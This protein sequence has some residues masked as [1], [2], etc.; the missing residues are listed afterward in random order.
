VGEEKKTS[1]SRPWKR[2]GRLSVFLPFVLLAVLLAVGMYLD[3]GTRRQET[4]GRGLWSPAFLQRWEDE[5]AWRRREEINELMNA[6]NA[7]AVA[8]LTH[9]LRDRNLKCGRPQLRRLD[10]SR[11]RAR[12]GLSS[13][14]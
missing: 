1:R 3:A 14:P 11:T 9:L 10:R 2:Y 5:R 6:G 12:W 4:G 13:E 8:R 7:E